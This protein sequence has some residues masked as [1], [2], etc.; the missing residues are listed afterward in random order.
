MFISFEGGD[1]AGKSTQIALTRA[2]L[3]EKGYTV[4][5]TREPGGNPIAEKIRTLL[6][7]KE[8]ARMDPYTEA[9]L[10]A[11]SRVQHVKETILPALQ[12]GEVVLS[13]RYFDSSVAYQGYGRQLGVDYVRDINREALSLCMPD[14]TYFLFLSPE[15]GKKRILSR[16]TPDRIEMEAQ[17]FHARVEKGFLMLSGQDKNRIRLIDAS[18]KVE[19]VFALIREDLEGLMDKKAFAAGSK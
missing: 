3:E 9:L 4:L 11:A 17:D 14:R 10:Y 2:Y 6:L 12:R 13:D 19:E 15:E 7:D 5:V 8:N 1:G 16:N 18:S